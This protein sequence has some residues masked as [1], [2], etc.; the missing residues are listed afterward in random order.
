MPRTVHVHAETAV[1]VLAINRADFVALLE[2]EPRIAI[3]MLRDVA[4]R[5]AQ[6]LDVPH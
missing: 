2:A 6:M 4:T 3:A 1:R 5:L